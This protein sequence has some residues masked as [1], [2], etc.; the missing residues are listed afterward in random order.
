M[1]T[2]I[3]L[4]K[5]EEEHIS[6]TIKSLNFCDQ[7]I[8]FDDESTDGTISISKECGAK[9]IKHSIDGDFA[10]QRNFAI[11]EIDSDWYLYI[12]AD[13]MVSPQL[14][15]EIKSIVSD[16][17]N[18]SDCF[19]IPR[20]DY[21][22]G[23]KIKYGDL[24][25][26]KLIRLVKKNTGKWVGKVH[27]TWHPKS[28]KVGHL[29]SPI[30]HNSHTSFESFLN[31]LNIYSTIKSQEF[32]ENKKHISIIHIIFGPVLKFI[33]LYVFKLGFMDKTVGFIHAMSMSL[34]VYLV[35]SKTWQL[36]N[37]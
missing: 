18:P 37:K 9:V 28:S 36:Q 32:F 2:A 15:L 26:F 4:A 29:K 13:E 14:G 25:N 1:L 10:S 20:Q 30:L 24:L 35:A 6:K 34:Y 12:D 11:K 31:H 21:F 7:V 16:T 27:E 22:L 23:Q 8:V 3:I 19:Y 33:Y 5:N 17:K